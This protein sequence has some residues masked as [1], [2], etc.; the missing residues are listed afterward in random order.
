LRTV[1]DRQSNE[2]SIA[3]QI[4][5]R[6]KRSKLVQG[7]GIFV[8]SGQRQRLVDVEPTAQGSA[9]DSSGGWVHR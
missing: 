6:T 3:R 4:S 2:M 1:F 7:L 8:R 5:R 9:C